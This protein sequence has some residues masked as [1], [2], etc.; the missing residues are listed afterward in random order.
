MSS[1][2]H[3]LHNWLTDGG[4]VISLTCQL[5]FT[6]RNIAATDWI[7]PR[8]AVH[9]EGLGQLKTPMT[10]GTD[11]CLLI[12]GVQFFHI[13]I[14]GKCHIDVS[15]NAFHSEHCRTHHFGL[16]KKLQIVT[17]AYSKNNKIYW[18]LLKKLERTCWQGSPPRSLKMSVKRGKEVWEVLWNNGRILFYNLPNMSH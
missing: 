4:E 2:P 15:I 3:F 5:A 6:P 16:W 14:W 13:L 7:N 10:L 11:S 8:A 18:T 9:L 12:L 1:L 17:N